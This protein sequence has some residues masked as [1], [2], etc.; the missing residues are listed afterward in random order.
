MTDLVI[1][2]QSQQIAQKSK[3]RGSPVS[4]IPYQQVANHGSYAP[5]VQ[6]LDFVYHPVHEDLAVKHFMDH[7]LGRDSRSA[8]FGY[9]PDYYSHG[10]FKYAELQHSLKAVG[11]AGYARL[12]QRA[13]LLYPAT[14]SY[15]AAVRN[16]NNAMSGPNLAD[17]EATLISVMLLSM[18]EVM[19]TPRALGLENLT[20]HLQGAMSIAALFVKK[21]KLTELHRRLLGTV[22]QASTIAYWIQNKPLPPE[23]PSILKE[24]KFHQD[25]IHARFL[26]IIVDLIG[27]RAAR[28]QGTYLSSR[29]VCAEA[30][31]LD[32]SLSHFAEGLSRHV[33]FDNM[34]AQNQELVYN[35]HYHGPYL[36]EVDNVIIRI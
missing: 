8:Q 13:D 31:R 16:I 12:T 25:S 14:K 7:H 29:D 28:E 5:P 15:V 4:V 34:T 20:K 1:F 33:P 11:L 30:Q 19:I 18:F 6:P 22:V 36:C 17:R 9:L 10:G 2:D 27:F 24:A 26:H 3:A 23:F 21:A 32:N 35:A